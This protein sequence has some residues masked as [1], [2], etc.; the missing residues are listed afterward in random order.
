MHLMNTLSIRM[1]SVD[2]QKKKKKKI[3]KLFSQNLI[4]LQ[5]CAYTVTLYILMHTTQPVTDFAGT[6][7]FARLGGRGT[8]RTRRIKW[9][10]L[11]GIGEGNKVGVA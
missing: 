9:V 5:Y 1:F 10:W 6:C 8:S 2:L 3:T 11:K 7:C 4:S